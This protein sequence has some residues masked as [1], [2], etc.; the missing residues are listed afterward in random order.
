VQ[1]VYETL[2][3]LIEEVGGN[4]IKFGVELVQFAILAVG[5]WFLAIGFGKRRGILVNAVDRQA[6]KTTAELALVDSAPS[7]VESA[8]VD[9]ERI[10]TQARAEADGMVR[11]A[12]MEAESIRRDAAASADAESSAILERAEVAVQTE[13][14]EMEAEVRDTLVNIVADATRSVM[15]EQLSLPEQREL[16]QHAILASV[17]HGSGQTPQARK[18]PSTKRRVPAKSQSEVS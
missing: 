6:Q 2:N 18:G 16:I 17:G 10:R 15:N 4:P 12:T 9:A 5:F 1:A 7:I 3:L 14:A 8:H 13:I 11:E